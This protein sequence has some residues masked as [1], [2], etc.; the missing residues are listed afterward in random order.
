MEHRYAR[1]RGDPVAQSPPPG[2]GPPPVWDVLRQGGHLPRPHPGTYNRGRRAG[3]PAIPS[4]SVAGFARALYSNVSR[5]RLLSD[6]HAPTLCYRRPDEPGAS[7][8]STGTPAPP[9]VRR[10]RVRRP[11][12]RGPMVRR[13]FRRGPVVR[14]RTPVPPP[15]VSVRGGPSGQRRRRRD[16][17]LQRVRGRGR[18]AATRLERERIRRGSSVRGRDCGSRTVEERW[19]RR[20][21]GG[22]R[23]GQEAPEVGGERA[24]ETAHEQLERSVR[25]TARSG[26]G[27]RRRTQAVQVRD[28]PDG[29]DVHRGPARPARP[30]T[31][32]H[33][34]PHDCGR[35]TVSPAVLRVPAAAVNAVSSYRLTHHRLA[36]CIH[37]VHRPPCEGVILFERNIKKKKKKITQKPN[38]VLFKAI[39]FCSYSITYQYQN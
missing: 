30:A 28:A 12:R 8:P 7:P 34:R 10:V 32:G 18:R 33:R 11:F 22:G 6:A 3:S 37:T 21:R 17:L 1:H 4:E 27:R 19:R 15:V 26:A 24:R 36:R 20:A 5:N 25:P 9:R 23:G 14:R 35:Q 31:D 38:Q 16:R 29:P 13:R 2:S 39:A